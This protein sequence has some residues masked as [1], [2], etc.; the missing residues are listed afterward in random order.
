MI[1]EAVGGYIAISVASGNVT[2][3]TNNGT[4][5]QARNAVI[6]FTGSPGTDRTVTAPDVE[7]TYWLVNGVGDSSNILFKASGGSTVTIPAGSSAKVYTDGATLA[8]IVAM[9]KTGLDATVTGA[10]QLGF[11]GIGMA[12]SNILD[13][14]QSTTGNAQGKILNSNGGTAATVQWRLGNG[15]SEMQ[16]MLFGASYITSGTD[17][18]DGVQLN[19][20]GA[21]GLTLVTKAVQPIYF[22]ING[23]EVA[24]FT[25]AANFAV[26]GTDN[27][28]AQNNIAAC[29]AVRADGVLNASSTG[30]TL[31][32]NRT[33]DGTVAEFRSA[34]VIQGSVSISGSTTSY[35]TSSD[36]SLKEEIKP[37]TE[38]GHLIDA[39][40]VSEFS[41]KETGEKQAAGFVAQD[42]LDTLAPQIPGLVN[43]RD[44]GLLEYD[45]SKLVPMMWRELQSLRARLAAAS[46]P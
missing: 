4:A 21:G 7:K 38:V 13:I 45:P 17:R 42:L 35:N 36:A 40:M 12:P 37:A 3:S 43:E 11:L 27:Q 33:T 28:P 22:G 15:T 30:V 25:T 23:A 20:T 16:L 34:G 46:I 32:I 31:D 8:V 26:G 41:W 24:R 10:V 2:L 6:K 18:Q 19:S 9:F 44:D 1:D 5:D 14:T 39:A 29:V